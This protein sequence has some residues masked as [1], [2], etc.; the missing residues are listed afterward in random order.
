MSLV[1]H[2]R[3]VR[4]AGHT[5]ILGGSAKEKPLSGVSSVLG[6]RLP[7]HQRWPHRAPLHPAKKNT[8]PPFD[9]ASLSPE[10][11]PDGWLVKSQEHGAP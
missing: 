10:M 5:P 7:R 9:S 8:S 4:G 3:A 6:F 1:K 11:L 2:G